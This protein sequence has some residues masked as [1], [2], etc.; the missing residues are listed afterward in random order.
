LSILYG[1]RFDNH[2]LVQNSGILFLPSYSPFS[3]CEPDL[4]FNNQEPRPDLEIP[5][6]FTEIRRIAPLFYRGRVD[7]RFHPFLLSS[8]RFYVHALQHAESQPEI[9]FL[10]LITC[11]EILSNFFEYKQDDLL[12][13][14]IKAD[15]AKI[16]K[17]LEGGYEIVQRIRH[18]LLNVKRR[19][20]KTI[21]RLLSPYFFKQTEAKEFGAL[22]EKNISAR[23][24]AAYDLRS[25]YVHSGVNFGTHIKARR[26]FNNEVMIGIRAPDIGNKNLEKILFKSPTLLG[27][28]RIIRYCLLRFIHLYGT[29]VDDRLNE[30]GLS[31]STAESIAIDL[32]QDDLAYHL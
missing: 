1:K 21:L 15:L 18:Q 16:E 25:N 8:G 19:F 5:L 27:M 13:A 3:V 22:D 11:G 23:I 2:G 28:E 26:M 30:K 29:P 7:E 14:E 31:D 17:Q 10:D 20:V 32:D 24:R 12:D 9:A 4:P 6:S